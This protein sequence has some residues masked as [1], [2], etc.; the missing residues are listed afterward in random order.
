M[1]ELFVR[2]GVTT[3]ARGELVTAIELPIPAQRIASVHVRRTRRRGH[4]L[5]SVTLTCGVDATGVTRL[6]YG[7]VGPR[8]VLV[9]D[10][11]GVLADPVATD[12]AKAPILEAMF[13]AASP[14]PRSMRAGPEVPPG[15]ATRPRPAGAGRSDRPPGGGGVS[16]MV[17]TYP[18]EVTVNG[19]RRALEV[20]GH[21]SLLDVIRDDLSLTGA[22]ECCLVGECGACT[23]MVDGRTVDSCLVLAVEV[24]GAELTT[25]EGLADGRRA[26]PHPAG[27]PGQGRRA[28]RVL[29]PG[30]AAVRMRASRGARAPDLGGG[31]GGHGRE[32]V[33]VRVLPADH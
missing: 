1:D 23:V 13:A 19:R 5:A 15:D 17:E 29:H 22:K 7:S 26:G 11:S 9:T 10:E 33:P 14:S 28:V 24:D 20:A 18:I 32:P 30:P 6:A 25:V 12:E 16:D 31:P 4:D 2:S 8:A 27:V 3:L 21:H